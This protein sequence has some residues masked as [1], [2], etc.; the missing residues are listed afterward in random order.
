M[1]NC[2]IYSINEVLHTI[3][4]ELLHAGMM[5]DEDSQISNMTT[6]E[7][8]I[9][10]KVLKKRVLLDANVIG[11]IEIIIPL[12]NISPMYFEF[13]YT[14]YRVPPELTLNKEIISVLSLAAIPA[15]GYFN[16][17][18]SFVLTSNNSVMNTA[19]RIGNSVSPSSIL[20]NTHLELV[21]YNTVV[22]YAN[23][24]VLANFGLRAVV[25][26][27]SNLNNIQPRSYKNF[28]M[29]CTLAVKAY[30]YN[31]LII[32]IN[33]GMLTGGQE[34]GMFKSILEGYS[35]AEEE[36]RTFLKEVW[37]SVAFM[38]DNTRYARYL[39]S[40]LAPDV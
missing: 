7:D 29:L 30:L 9:L 21:G 8:K 17:V 33:S 23:Y 25:E 15:L 37:G 19:D 39:G 40:M 10:N 3:P 2:L 38:N 14:I 24:R 32:P 4:R 35:S 28:S 31:K 6:I 12:A 1:S 26:N 13:A 27:E 11:G 34:L 16:T 5:I 18:G 36:Y 20:N 22:V